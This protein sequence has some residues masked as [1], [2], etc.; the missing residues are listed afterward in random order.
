V[1]TSITNTTMKKLTLFN[2]LFAVLFTVFSTGIFAQTNTSASG[3]FSLQG[4]LTTTTGTPIADGSHSVT[5][6]VYANGS[7][8][9]S[10]SQTLN[11][12]TMGGLF[13]AMI[14]A[15]GNGGAT[16]HIMPE[17][18]YQLGVS[19][20]GSAE[21][22]PKLQLGS[23]I[24]SLT[25]N[26]AANAD[27]VAGFTVSTSGNANLR[28]NTLFTLN[29]AGKI[30]SSL[31]QGSL[32]TSINGMTGAVNLQGAGNLGI[33]TNGNTV[34]LNVT[35]GSGGSLTLPFTQTTNLATGNTAFSITNSLGGSA[36]T[37]I[38]SGT[39]NALSL[40]A[41]SGSAINA[42]STGGVGGASTINVSNT[43]GG[44]INAVANAGTGAAITV[45][46]LASSNTA[47]LLNALNSVGTSVFDVSA[48]G[49]TTINATAGPAL[50]ATT[51]A[52]TDAVVKLQNLSSSAGANLLT[53][54][55]STG[56]T[57]LNVA[58]TG[59]TTINSTVGDALN[60][61]TS[62]AGQAALAINGGLKITG[63]AVGTGTINLGQLTTTINNPLVKANSIILLTVNAA[64]AAAVPLQIASQANGSFVVSAI[65]TLV[66]VTGNVS[67]NYLII[68]Q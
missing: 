30:D 43:S 8:T 41:G 50:T 61:A 46:N 4:M 25:A 9:A 52:S 27:S 40:T 55:N 42:T 67:F 7:N 32:V 37:F 34:T 13:T 11:V 2:C 58:A 29:S 47:N 14:G 16:L 51:T 48:S 64:G 18:S 57:A 65:T 6:N 21:L 1:L 24:N 3:E 10:F 28:A 38:N 66:G 17:T 31:L 35:G 20:D 39:G 60:V 63:G 49:Q 12:T 15:N 56:G 26:L 5:V 23:A 36:A 19:V 59:Q 22:A 44:A 45:Q 68:N 33:T 53:A 54:L 62:A